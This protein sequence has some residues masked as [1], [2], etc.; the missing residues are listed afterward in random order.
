MK[1][2]E[3]DRGNPVDSCNICQE[4]AKV[5]NN[6]SH[7]RLHSSPPRENCGFIGLAFEGHLEWAASLFW[8]KAILRGRVQES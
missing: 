3:G 2:R 7:C 5:V 1:A 8:K 4:E 6:L